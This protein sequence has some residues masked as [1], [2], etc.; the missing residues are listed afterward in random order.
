MMHD[1]I[2]FRATPGELAF[3]VRVINA[4]PGA[5]IDHSVVDLRDRMARRVEEYRAAT[6]KGAK[7]APA[8]KEAPAKDAPPVKIAKKTAKKKRK[9]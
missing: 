1:V 3:L 8:K 4:L 2:D 5:E 7:P 9:A 6:Q